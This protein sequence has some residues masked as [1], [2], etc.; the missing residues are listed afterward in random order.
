MTVALLPISGSARLLFTDTDEALWGASEAAEL[1]PSVGTLPSVDAESGADIEP[2]ALIGADEA[3]GFELLP[4]PELPQAASNIASIPA[5]TV[6]GTRVRTENSAGKIIRWRLTIMSHAVR[7]AR[8]EPMR[9]GDMPR[10]A[11]CSRAGEPCPAWVGRLARPSPGG[12][13]RVGSLAVGG[14]L[15]VPTCGVTAH[16]RLHPTGSLDALAGRPGRPG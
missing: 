13:P 16:L 15:L 3:G 11:Y 7:R 2:G 12:R 1:P 14:Q 9:L 10:K 8:R 6:N 4:P 5:V